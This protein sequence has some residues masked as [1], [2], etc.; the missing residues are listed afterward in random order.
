MKPRKK[1]SYTMHGQQQS[2]GYKYGQ[3][4]V[5][6]SDVKSIDSY[7]QLSIR[8]KSLTINKKSKISISNNFSYQ[9]YHS[10]MT[11]TAFTHSRK[12]RGERRVYQLHIRLVIRLAIRDARS[13][14]GFQ[15]RV[16][17]DKQREQ[18]IRVNVYE[19]VNV[20]TH[21]Q[22]VHSHRDRG[23]R[24]FVQVARRGTST[25]V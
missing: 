11:Y 8:A 23:I 17:G 14:S 20:R 2:K 5:L 6:G 19:H 24:M 21:V 25:N 3:R 9:S 22:T 12:W 7:R 4:L 16:K 15:T 10:V 1:N 13:R 18:F